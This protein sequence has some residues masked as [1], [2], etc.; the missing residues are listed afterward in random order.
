ML[1]ETRSTTLGAGF[2][3]FD[4][5]VT[6]PATYKGLLY[7]ANTEQFELNS[8]PGGRVTDYDADGEVATLTL[9]IETQIERTASFVTKHISHN[10]VE[11]FLGSRTPVSNGTAD[12]YTDQS[13]N[14]GKA[15]TV[16]YW[17]MLGMDEFHVG[18]KYVTAVEVRT[19]ETTPVTLVADTDYTLDAEAGM[20]Y[21]LPDSAGSGKILEADF[22]VD[23]SAGSVLRVSSATHK[24]IEGRLLFLGR[25]TAGPDR[26]WYMPSVYLAPSG[27]FALKSR[28]TVQRIGFNCRIQQPED[29]DAIIELHGG[30]YA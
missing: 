28:D 21:L 10:A 15:C 12:D 26:T 2:V 4:R 29:G 14:G 27:P 24:R 23:G 13:I 16:K 9:D 7:L 25:N 19:V 8:T 1:P 30:S 20:I 22:S 3:F 17:Y 18:A 5:L 6:R 11:L